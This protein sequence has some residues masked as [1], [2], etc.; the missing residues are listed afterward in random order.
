LKHQGIEE[1]RRR[2]KT[3]RNGCP[4][5]FL[6]SDNGC[7][8]TSKA[9]ERHCK[10]LGIKQIFT[11]YSNPKGNADTERVI[12]TIKEEL[13]YINEFDLKSE[14]SDAF[15]NWVEFYNFKYPHSAL[16]YKSPYQV[17]REFVNKNRKLQRA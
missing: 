14:F 4:R 17:E 11:S 2:K 10:L 5:L 15:K 9:F 16:K 7:Q 13:V 1:E 8:P 3:A 6:V 12:R